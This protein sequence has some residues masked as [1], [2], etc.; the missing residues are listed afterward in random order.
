MLAWVLIQQYLLAVAKQFHSR[1]TRCR[2][3]VSTAAESRITV[4]VRGLGK[5]R[6]ADWV[7][8]G[9]ALPII[10]QSLGSEDINDGF[11]R[12]WPKRVT[13]PSLHTLPPIH[14]SLENG[15]SLKR[16]AISC[17]ESHFP[18]NHDYEKSRRLDTDGYW[19]KK[20]T[21]G[22]CLCE[23]MT[24]RGHVESTPIIGIIF[25]PNARKNHK[26]LRVPCF[27]HH[28]SS[29]SSSWLRCHP[30]GPPNGSPVPCEQQQQRPH[31]H[32]PHRGS[33]KGRDNWCQP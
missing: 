30:S 2:G 28:T 31:P 11:F 10:W 14:G 17:G 7:V 26:L 24:N 18:S 20:S 15:S 8:G 6:C 29:S 27:I 22:P 5:S 23:T 21:P 25:L 32:S 4:V 12:D 33:M 1:G 3:P 19:W 13:T 9:A 16:Y